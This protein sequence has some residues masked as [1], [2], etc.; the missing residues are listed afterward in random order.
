LTHTTGRLIAA[1]LWLAYTAGF[2]VWCQRLTGSTAATLFTYVL[3]L[4][5]LTHLTDSLGH[6]IELCLLLL[7]A[8]L[9]LATA[10]PMPARTA[11]LVARSIEQASQDDIN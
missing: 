8:V 4:I 9:L 11:A 3:V 5:W 2:A 7:V 1:A 6:P 10:A